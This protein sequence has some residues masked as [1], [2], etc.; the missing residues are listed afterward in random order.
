MRR[1]GQKARRAGGQEF[2]M[3]G[4]QEDIMLCDK[5]AKKSVGEEVKK[6]GCQ[7]FRRCVHLPKVVVCQVQEYSVR[8]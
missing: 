4:C 5:K 6:S 8:R 7:E 1:L 3:T 2:R